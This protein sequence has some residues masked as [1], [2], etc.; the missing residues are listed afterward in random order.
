VFSQIVDIFK[1]ETYR[2]NSHVVISTHPVDPVRGIA[3]I[4]STISY[5]VENLREHSIDFLVRGHIDA[6]IIL[7]GDTLQ[8]YAAA[9]V[10]P[11]YARI[12]V[13]HP[14]T[15]VDVSVTDQ[16]AMQ[17]LN[18]TPYEN[19]KLRIELNREQLGFELPLIIPARESIS[20]TCQLR[21]AVRVRTKVLA[22]LP[23]VGSSAGANIV[24]PNIL[25]TNDWNVVGL[26]DF[27][28]LALVSFNLNPHYVERSTSDAR[29]NETRS[30]RIKEYHQVWQNPVVAIEEEALLNVAE[31][32][33]YV[34][35][36][37]RGEGVSAQ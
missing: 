16:S 27:R 19:G 14:R 25:T 22:G 35:G 21:R 5:D 23:Y 24:G 31:D 29:H 12:T 2:R 8:G 13:T 34:T 33:L 32:R 26:T 20:L 17:V 3:V 37:A 6:D 4:D 15:H 9:T 36:R 10:A 18:D 11:Q 1:S 30:Q 7:R 28:S